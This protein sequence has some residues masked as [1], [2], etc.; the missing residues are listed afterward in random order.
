MH[1]RCIVQLPYR[2][3]E[4]ERRCVTKLLQQVR[5]LVPITWI[6]VVD[7]PLCSTLL[8]GST[9]PWNMGPHTPHELTAYLHI[10]A[11]ICNF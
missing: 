6:A 2:I 11:P 3:L 5:C 4:G 8:R 7:S 1:S 10:S 9:A